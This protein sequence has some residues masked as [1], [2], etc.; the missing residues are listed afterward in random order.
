MGDYDSS[1]WLARFAPQWWADPQH[2]KIPCNWAFN[3][4][5]DRRVPQ[6]LDY[7]RTHQL[8]SDWFISGDCGAGYLNP[9]ALAAPRLDPAVPDGWQLW[10]QYNHE[11]FRRY[12]LSITGFIIEGFARNM[13][14][15]GFDAYEKFSPDG[16]MIETS[17]KTFGFVGLHNGTLPCIRHRMDLDGSPAQAGAKLAAKVADEKKAFADGPQF[18]MARTVLKSPTWHADT[19]TAAKAALGGENIEFVDAYTFFLL[20]KTSLQHK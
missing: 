14:T 19:M 13:G 18:L 16:L 2:D 5:L 4:N 17:S 15:R 12:D 9:G 8:A 20:L 1:A 10:T 6:V 3:P 11:Y 7:V